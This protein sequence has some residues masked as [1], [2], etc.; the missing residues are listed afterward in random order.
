MAERHWRFGLGERV[1]VAL[2]MLTVG[3]ATTGALAAIMANTGTPTPEL[4]EALQ[5]LNLVWLVFATAILVGPPLIR[6]GW[7]AFVPGGVPGE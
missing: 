7:A 1:I 4:D 3:G 2:F 5:A 6:Y